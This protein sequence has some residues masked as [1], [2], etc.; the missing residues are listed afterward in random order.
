[1]YLSD[2]SFSLIYQD[3]KKVMALTFSDFS[4]YK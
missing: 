2:I 3:L 1:M 4:N